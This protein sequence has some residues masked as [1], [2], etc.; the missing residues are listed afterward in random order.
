MILLNVYL[1]FRRFNY[2]VLLAKS[3]HNLNLRNE[4]TTFKIHI[5]RWSY[6][7]E[8]TSNQV[9]NNINEKTNLKIKWFEYF[10]GIIDLH[11]QIFLILSK[12]HLNLSTLSLNLF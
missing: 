1:T 4:N 3:I 9:E 2:T 6:I 11:T 8:K 10:V 7:N 5:Y 12:V